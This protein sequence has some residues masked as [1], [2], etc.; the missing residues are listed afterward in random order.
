MACKIR[1]GRRALKFHARSL[2]C[3]AQWA[4]SL[5]R[6]P[7]SGVGSLWGSTSCSLQQQQLIR[8]SDTEH[9]SED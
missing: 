1:G 2:D 8:F 4:R 3:D 6:M 7:A 5:T 9:P